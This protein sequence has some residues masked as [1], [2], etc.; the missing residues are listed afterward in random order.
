MIN[1]KLS[2]MENRLLNILFFNNQL[3]HYATAAPGFKY[4]LQ[5]NQY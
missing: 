4:I 1:V 3:N 5:L 2:S